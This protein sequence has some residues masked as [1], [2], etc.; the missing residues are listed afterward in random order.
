VL[1]GP[2]RIRLLDIAPDG[3]LLV[4]HSEIRYVVAA[5]IAGARERDLSWLDTSTTPNLS[6]DGKRILFGDASGPSGGLYAVCLRNTDGSPVIRLGDGLNFALSPD[7]S[8]A[9]ALLLKDPPQ[10]ELLPTGPGEARR[11]ENSN[12]E[13]YVGMGWM[14]NSQEFIFAGNEAGR[15]NRFY[16]QSIG[17]GKARALTAEGFNSVGHSIPISPDGKQFV[18]FDEH[19]HAWNLCQVENGKCAL[20]PGSEEQDNPVQ[21]SADGRYIY[22]SL[23]QPF[24]S[25]WR[26]ELATGHRKLWEQVAVSDPV[27]VN[28]VLPESITPD[29]KSFAYTYSRC[30]DELYLVDGVN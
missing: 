1:A 2:G 11:L 16:I 28:E 22:V 23:R 27:G 15:S 13:S 6:R 17:N 8:W 21:W 9:W 29:G 12:I 5:S 24:T 19:N 10:V 4:S 18:A 14:P 20:L 7:G 3:R 25:F 26:I 30:L